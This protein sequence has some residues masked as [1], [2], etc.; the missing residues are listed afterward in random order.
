M[1][2]EEKDLICTKFDE[3]MKAYDDWWNVRDSNI[4][5]RQKLNQE[6]D[7]ETAEYMLHLS[8]LEW[9]LQFW[10]CKMLQARQQFYASVKEC[11]F[12]KIRIAS[13][14]KYKISRWNVEK[15]EEETFVISK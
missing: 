8:I 14:N 6:K 10:F 11:G 3:Y 4:E 5:S 13:K 12:Q 15:G 7:K 2:P 9:Q 1:N